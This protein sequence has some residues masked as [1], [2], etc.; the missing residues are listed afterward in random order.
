MT[1]EDL[2]EV[3]CEL[4]SCQNILRCL[5][6]AD[7]QR[8]WKMHFERMIRSVVFICISSSAQDQKPYVDL[9]CQGSVP[10]FRVRHVVNSSIELWC[11]CQRTQ[12]VNLKLADTAS[13]EL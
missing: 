7:V 13:L 9:L 4:T 5:L 6:S 1:D 8:A 11:G 12:I 2:K 10:V 3:S